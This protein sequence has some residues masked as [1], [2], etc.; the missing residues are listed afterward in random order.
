MPEKPSSEAIWKYSCSSIGYQDAVLKDSNAEKIFSFGVSFMAKR[1]L[2]GGGAVKPAG[3]VRN[4]VNKAEINIMK[5]FCINVFVY[6]CNFA[7][8]TCLNK[9]G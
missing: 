2:V 9:K 5:R 8:Q 4:F 1:Y 7:K 3:F 6:L